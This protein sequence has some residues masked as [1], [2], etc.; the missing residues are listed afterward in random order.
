[1]QLSWKEA[2]L[3]GLQMPQ[4]DPNTSWP[5]AASAGIA[6]L[7]KH[8][9]ESETVR[10][11]LAMCLKGPRTGCPDSP[12]D[13]LVKYVAEQTGQ[14]DKSNPAVNMIFM[15]KIM[16]PVFELER[17]YLDDIA[18]HNLDITNEEELLLGFS[19][20][21][22]GSIDRLYERW[23]DKIVVPY[24]SLAD[25][26]KAKYREAL[27]DQ[28][29]EF[30]YT[31]YGYQNGVIVNRQTLAEAFPGEMKEIDELLDSTRFLSNREIRNYFKMLRRAYNCADIARLEECWAAV[32]EVW[33]KIPPT[34]RMFPVHGMENGYEHP[35]GVS[36]EFRLVVRTDYGRDIISRIRGATPAYAR[37]IGVDEPLVALAEQKM[38]CID[39]GVFT[40]V[41]RAGVCANFRL[42]GQVVPNRQEI[43]AR[44]GKIFMDIDT[45]RAAV[46][47]YR[48]IA[49]KHCAP[50]TAQVV[51]DMITV[52]E[53]LAHTVCH[54][55]T[56]PIGCTPESDTAVGEKKNLVEEAK[57]TIG[58]LAAVINHLDPGK[59]AEVAAMSIARVCR[60]MAKTTLENPT[61]Q[62]Y[63]RENLVMA[64]LLLKCGIVRITDRVEVNFDKA[65]LHNW[66]DALRRFYLDVVRSYHSSDPEKDVIGVEGDYC[67]RT[68]ELESWIACVNRADAK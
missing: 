38:T 18:G 25:G 1:M 39:M 40:T 66:S 67:A 58:G 23:F 4:I 51:A 52:D 43:L 42:A 55:C 22:A 47:N 27:K 30:D 6:A 2:I 21:L 32:D 59:R 54:E 5:E 44:G 36:P 45:N 14:I 15:R 64:N 49:L 17:K 26:D 31:V 62:P 8:L 53:M 33:I 41:V 11:Y 50:D 20:E 63:V 24:Q 19:N 10:G 57:A 3:R 16:F 35:F 56:H 61:A 13:E 60:F 28:L 7:A 46:Q 12:V 9:R 34:C 29:A 48:G 68:P 37:K 65:Y